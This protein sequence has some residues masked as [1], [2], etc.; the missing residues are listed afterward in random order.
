MIYTPSDQTASTRT[1]QST[2]SLTGNIQ[3]S[4]AHGSQLM[5]AVVGRPP[6]PRSGMTLVEL[7][8][9]LG[10]VGLLV[11]MGVPALVGYAKQVHLKTATRKVIGLVSLARSLSI[12][13]RES[14]AVIFDPETQELRLVNMKTGEPREEDVLR[15]PRSVSLQFYVGGDTAAEMKVVFRPTGSLAGRTITIVLASREREQTVVVTAATGF[16]AV[17]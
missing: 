6:W 8:V 14:H 10:V 3:V 5:T 2:T 15:L 7:L 13:S 17:Q 12:S 4:P 11:G 16:I 9:V 1:A